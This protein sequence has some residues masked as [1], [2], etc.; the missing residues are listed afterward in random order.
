VEPKF[1]SWLAGKQQLVLAPIKPGDMAKKTMAALAMCTNLQDL[2]GTS[3]MDFIEC[4]EANALIRSIPA[5]VRRVTLARND[6]MGVFPINVQYFRRLTALEAL[7]LGYSYMHNEWVASLLPCIP[8]VKRLVINNNPLA[9]DKDNDDPFGTWK[10]PANLEYLDISNIGMDEIGVESLLGAL[11]ACPRLHTLDTSSNPIRNPIASEFMFSRSLATLQISYCNMDDQALISMLERLPSTLQILDVK[12]NRI[13]MTATEFVGLPL[14]LR[15][16]YIHGNFLNAAGI[17]SLCRMLQG[18]KSITA[19][20]LSSQDTGE[21]STWKMAQGSAFQLIPTTLQTLELRD[22]RLKAAGMLALP[23]L[24]NLATLELRH[25]PQI[26]D[27][28]VRNLSKLRQLTDLDLHNTGITDVGFVGS[29]V[30]I[31]TRLRKLDIGE[32]PGITWA[33]ARVMSKSPTTS[34]TELSITPSSMQKM[35][36]QRIIRALHSL[37]WFHGT[38]NN[39]KTIIKKP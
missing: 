13:R 22:L 3:C 36:F 30:P 15:E 1:R 28:G 9:S 11:V 34:L 39:N 27:K 31:L 35:S 24:A 20:D 25:N 29:V 18:Q 10:M 6:A 21:W 33:S 5:S 14:H 23:P 17:G 16:L 19:L 4:E 38:T 37:K 2:D 7:N 12:Y 32:N 26:R 8:H